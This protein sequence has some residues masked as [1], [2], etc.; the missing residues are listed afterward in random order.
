M[1]VTISSNVKKK[2]SFVADEERVFLSKFKQAYRTAGNTV[3]FY[4]GDFVKKGRALPND[5]VDFD[6]G[7][8]A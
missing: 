6:H 3:E 8:I 1:F 5:G 4:Y 7:N 2:D